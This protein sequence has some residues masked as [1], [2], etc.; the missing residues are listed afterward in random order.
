MVFL[1][2]SPTEI[3]LQIEAA[4]RAQ[5]DRQSRQ[6]RHPDGRWNAYLNSMCIRTVLFWLQTDYS[7]S[8]RVWLANE[9][10]ELWGAVNGTAIALNHKRFVFIPSKQID[11]EE[12]IVPQ[13]WVDLA[14]WAG[15]YFVAVQID[16]E[17]EWLRLWGYT[18]HAQLKTKGEYQAGDRSYVLDATQL[19]RDVTALWV[20]HQ[21]NP[22]ESTQASLLPAPA[23][24]PP[25]IQSLLQ[26]SDLLPP[27]LTLPYTQWSELLCHGE[28]RQQLYQQWRTS[29]ARSLLPSSVKLVNWLQHRFEEGW[30]ALEN[31][32]QTQPQL[33]YSLRDRTDS[34]GAVRRARSIALGDG[35]HV[36][37][38]VILAEVERS[39]QIRVR[40]YPGDRPL[41]AN[42]SLALLTDVGEVVQWVQ[43]REDADFIQLKRFVCPAGKPFWI[44]VALD[45][46]LFLESFV[47]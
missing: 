26:L 7:L 1:Y 25:Q 16:P 13:E 8:A 30:E 33:A 32:I 23:H 39:S 18:T 24:A 43:A 29:E 44:Q 19:V 3:V 6:L 28:T 2:A 40:L 4:I 14:E 10:P 34:D 38:M 31:L 37:L 45:E 17:G 5:A 20:I 41:P 11:T 46:P 27:R 15:D 42:L 9:L 22:T 36:I 21:L 35:H 12:L 47:G